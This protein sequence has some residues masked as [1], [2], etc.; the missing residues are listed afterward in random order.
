M[1][2]LKNKI[3]KLARRIAKAFSP[4]PT[5]ILT[6]RER[7]SK[8]DIEVILSGVEKSQIVL[9]IN[10]LIRNEMAEWVAAAGTQ[11]AAG[12]GIQVHSCGAIDALGRLLGEINF[13]TEDRRNDED[14]E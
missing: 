13:L 7:L 3:T 10:Q 8:K 14:S 5:I 6:E 4:T 1:K 11:S 9:A 2:T 12:T